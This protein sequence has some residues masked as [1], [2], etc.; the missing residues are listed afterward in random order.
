MGQG[1]DSTAASAEEVAAE[2]S[3]VDSRGWVAQADEWLTATE[4]D[5]LEDGSDWAALIGAAPPDPLAERL[6][7]ARP[8]R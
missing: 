4:S 3:L 5:A 1:V 7:F 2:A 8:T 6:V